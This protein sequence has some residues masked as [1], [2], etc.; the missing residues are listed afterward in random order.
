MSEEKPKGLR[1][2]R[3]IRWIFG[4]LLV[5]MVGYV[6]WNADWRDY[7]NLTPGRTG[8][9][10]W[11]IFRSS[12]PTQGNTFVRKSTLRGTPLEPILPV[13]GSVIDIYER[14]SGGTKCWAYL[15][16]SAE[17]DRLRPKDIQRLPNFVWSFDT[18]GLPIDPNSARALSKLPCCKCLEISKVNHGTE[19]LNYICKINELSE[20]VITSDAFS[21]LPGITK[22]HK[23]LCSLEFRGDSER[24]S[25]EI[26]TEIASIPTLVQLKYVDCVLDSKPLHTI[27]TNNQ[28]N[29]LTFKDCKSVR[30]CNSLGF[31]CL[32]NVE[33]INA[34]N[35]HF[36]EEFFNSINGSPIGRLYLRRSFIPCK[37]STI[38]QKLPSVIRL[39]VSESFGPHFSLS[40]IDPES[41][42]EAIFAEGLEINQASLS[43]IV[44][45]PRILGLSIRGSKVSDEDFIAVSPSPSLTDIDVTGSTLSNSAIESFRLLHPKIMIKTTSYSPILF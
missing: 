12:F 6:A 5:A 3:R 45:L 20:L 37:I 21:G 41:R 8:M 35:T 40:D 18:N 11:K 4:W 10:T 30:C 22:H 15:E 24:L 31:D 44:S 26:L 23:N 29:V 32:S 33:T 27:K 34:W 28:L 19:C 38:L 2:W 7:D 13:I 42:L 25:E 43:R 36:E 39:S 17:G 9:L 16:V 1:T 14:V